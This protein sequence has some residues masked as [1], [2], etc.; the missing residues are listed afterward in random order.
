MPE[1]KPGWAIKRL[2][3]EDRTAKQ[4]NLT[5]RHKRLAATLKEK[6]GPLIDI[7]PADA[8]KHLEWFK[9]NEENLHKQIASF[10]AAPNTPYGLFQLKSVLR[11]IKRSGWTELIKVTRRIYL[12][13]TNNVSTHPDE[14]RLL[15][16][17]KETKAAIEKRAKEKCPQN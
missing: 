5:K 16:L 2:I 6:T 4:K 15:K 8:I 7:S 17:V 3:E 10:L 9:N 14:S 12:W 13:R 1:Q 11:N